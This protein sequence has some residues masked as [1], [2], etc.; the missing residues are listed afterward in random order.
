MAPAATTGASRFTHELCDP[1]LPGG[2]PP[3]A[4]FT[5]NPGVPFTPFQ[6]CAEP[7][8]SIGI[9]ETGSTSA[10]YAFWTFGIPATPGGYVEAATVSG[11]V[12]GL[13]PGNDHVYAYEP[14][15]PPGGNGE[16]RRVFQNSEGESPFYFSNAIFRIF[17]NCD[18]NYAP[19]C[20]AGPTIAIHDIAATEV[21]PNPPAL[22]GLRGSILAAGTTLRGHQTLAVEATDVG[23]GLSA[24]SVL[25]NGAPGGAPKNGDCALTT[26]DN[27]SYVGTIALSPTPCPPALAAEWL[28]DTES[29]PFQEGANTVQVCAS[30]FATTGEPNTT[31]LPA[32]TVDVDNSCNDSPVAGG[33]LLSAEFSRSHGEA[34]TV[35]YGK[36]AEIVGKLANNADEPIAGATLCVK[37]QT[38]GLQKT[39]EPITT[40]TTDAEG[41]YSFR[42]QPGPNRDL[43]VGYRHDTAQI[44]RDVRFFARARPTLWAK[45]GKLRNGERVRLQGRLPEPRAAG[46]VVVLQAHVPGSRRWITFRKATT[47]RKGRFRAAYHFTSTTRKITYR[48]RAVVPRQNDYPWDQGAS[49]PAPVTVTR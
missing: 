11:S 48:F 25:V 29:Y 23:G 22:S 21:D 46:R 42:V 1:A 14:G 28:L 12:S 38:L 9:A 34:K 27:N 18:G 7:G 19:G 15:W 26:V 30:D 49:K 20:G 40:A 37:S 36:G 8:G 17:I 33:E 24:V 6:T 16:S 13:G 3:T 32:Q 35:P 10:Q 41:A 43:V 31:C 44:A 45:P 2:A 4:S 39:A 5:V 47:G